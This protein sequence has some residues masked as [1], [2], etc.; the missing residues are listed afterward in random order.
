M[1]DPF[2]TIRTPHFVERHI[3]PDCGPI[4]SLSLL[5]R[6]SMDGRPSVLLT[7]RGE[8]FSADLFLDVEAVAGL[9]AMCIAT[10]ADAAER[11]EAA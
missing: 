9:G 4:I 10:V 2:A 3:E 1:N 8:G 6:G 11:K 7:M 5:L